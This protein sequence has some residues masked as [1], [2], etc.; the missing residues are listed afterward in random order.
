MNNLSTKKIL[1]VDDMKISR[2]LILKLVI[3]LGAT[4]ELL[5]EAGNGNEAVELLEKNSFDLIISDWNMPE[6]SGIELLKFC[7]ENDNFKKIPFVLLT[8]E[9]ENEK[10]AQALELKVDL[11][12]VKPLK[13]DEF[14][15]KIMK[16]K[17]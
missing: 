14:I 17:I 3:K 13:E 12:L 15:Q 8:S 9:S 6:M 5:S 2:K 10:I 1:V 7:K 4:E 16:L 11:Y